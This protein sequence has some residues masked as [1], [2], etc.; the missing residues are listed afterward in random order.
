M[1][2]RIMQNGAFICC[3][4][5]NT[6]LDYTIVFKTTDVSINIRTTHEQ[7]DINLV[8]E[9]SFSVHLTPYGD[10]VEISVES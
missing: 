3:T 2:I 10:K 4:H 7:L 1:L 9:K 6:F 8:S 5:V